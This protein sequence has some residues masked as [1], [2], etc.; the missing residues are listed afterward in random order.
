MHFTFFSTLLAPAAAL[1]D[2]RFNA[3]SIPTVVIPGIDKGGTSDAYFGIMDK[4]VDVLFRGPTKEPGCLL[5]QTLELVQ[6]C[7]RTNFCQGGKCKPSLDATPSYMWNLHVDAASNLANVAPTAISIFLLRDPVS[8]IKSLYNFWKQAQVQGPRLG[9]TIDA[10]V[11]FELEYMKTPSARKTLWTVLGDDESLVGIQRFRAYQSLGRD[12]ALWLG[13]SQSQRCR[14]VTGPYQRVHDVGANLTRCPV[15]IPFLSTAVYA[16]ALHHWISQMSPDNVAVV[17]SEAYFAD[18]SV[19][20]GLFPN[21]LFAWR[22]L[23]EKQVVNSGVYRT[24]PLSEDLEVTLRA[25]FDVPNA[26]LREFLRRWVSL[27]LRVIPDPDT[28][29]SWWCAEREA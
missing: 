5:R 29:G 28:P 25:F 19:L 7:Y 3:T 11:K 21:P 27:Q 16:P 8:R 2:L 26:R 23:L 15:I 22:H 13:P 24:T 4:E 17:Q 6:A 14:M 12:F 10:H 20:L 1:A 9:D 18:R